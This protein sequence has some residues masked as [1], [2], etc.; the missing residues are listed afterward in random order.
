MNELTRDAAEAM[1]WWHLHGDAA[2]RALDRSHRTSRARESTQGAD[3]GPIQGNSVPS[4]HR[5]ADRP[6]VQ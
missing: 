1:A 2:A 4:S 6:P 3:G 5:A